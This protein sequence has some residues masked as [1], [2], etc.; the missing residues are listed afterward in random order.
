MKQ[1]RLELYVE[2]GQE[3]TAR[4]ELYAAMLLPAPTHFRERPKRDEKPTNWLAA[5]RTN[6]CAFSGI[7][8]QKVAGAK[9]FGVRSRLAGPLFRLE[10]ARGAAASK[11]PAKES[12]SKLP[13]SKACRSGNQ[14]KNGS[15]YFTQG[16]DVK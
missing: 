4:W 7:S 2:A 6:D 8:P 5:P 13:H 12:G 14:K 16:G 11:L 1:H 15:M 10:L 3:V 9:R